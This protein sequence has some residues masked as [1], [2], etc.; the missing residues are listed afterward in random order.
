MTIGKVL[1]VCR[2]I[3]AIKIQSLGELDNENLC[4]FLLRAW[5][6]VLV[7]PQ[8]VYESKI[9]AINALFTFLFSR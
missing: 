7:S 3:V 2:F 8:F 4:L 5:N 6:E 1:V 9:G